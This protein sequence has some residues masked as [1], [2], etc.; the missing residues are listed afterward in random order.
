[1]HVPG[2]SPNGGDAPEQDIV[3]KQIRNAIE[4]GGLSRDVEEV[5]L[6]HGSPFAPHRRLGKI[7]APEV[8]DEAS[9]FGLVEQTDGSQVAVVFERP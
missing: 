4:D 7:S 5:A 9:A 1:M 8:V 3:V 2:F 6:M